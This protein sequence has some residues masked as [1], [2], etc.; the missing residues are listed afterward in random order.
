MIGSLAIEPRDQR[1]RDIGGAA[2]LA[3]PEERPRALAEA[4]DQ[5]GLGQQPQMAR[6]ARLRL[7]Q[8][9]GEVGDRQ[10]GLGEQRQ[11]AQ[12]RGFA[13][14]LERCGQ[15]GGAQL[16]IRHCTLSRRH[17]CLS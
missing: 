17:P 2:A 5:A 4:L 9:F 16:L 10:L 7:A 6:Q 12:A 3:Q 1:A 13:C 15:R 14:G 8:N 11:D